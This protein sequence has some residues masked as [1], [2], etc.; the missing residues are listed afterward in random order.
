MSKI[1]TLTMIK[2][3]ADIIE[4]FVRYTMQF[5]EKMFFID[6]GCT[7]GTI[8]ILH[9]LTKEGFDIVIYHEAAVFYEQYLLENTYI[10]KIVRE[11]QFDFLIPLDADEFL[12]ASQLTPLL[13]FE[14]LPKEK[15][16]LIKWK[17]YVITAENECNGFFL[18]SIKHVRIK[19][20]VTFTKVILPYKVLEKEEIYVS[21]GHHTVESKMENI[22]VENSQ[23]Y[24]AHFPVR[25]EEQILLKIYQGILCQLMSSYR[26]VVAFHWRK[27]IKEFEHSKLNLINYSQSYALPEGEIVDGERDIIIDPFDY[28]WCTDSIKPQYFALAKT[29][30]TWNLFK[31]AET[32]CL[33]SII[34]DRVLQDGKQRIFVYGT[35]NVAKSLFQY[36]NNGRYDILAYINSDERM[37]YG[38][39]EGKLI[40][41]PK[42]IG[43]FSYDKI[44]IATN[45]EHFKEI[46][47]TLMALGVKE[48][49][50]LTKWELIGQ[51]ISQRYN[52]V[53]DL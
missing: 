9:E 35:G 46:Y 16:T 32:I 26:S 7:D 13:C 49:K 47:K 1:L 52:S 44:V 27:L 34:D 2:N 31:L 42:K 14:T 51:I 28:E 3:E 24:I 5:A 25:S 8:E 48:E 6:N 40:I 41:S 37:E 23:L 22:T 20:S 18:D 33:K 15:I 29:D 17:T 11:N 10:K 39:F 38:T 19:E 45:T 53:N 30:V 21:M 4:T 43:Y 36:I 12:T 50:V